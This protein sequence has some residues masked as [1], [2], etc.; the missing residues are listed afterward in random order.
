MIKVKLFF[1]T[2]KLLAYLI[3]F[4]GAAYSFYSKDPSVII[5][6]MSASAALVALKTYTTSKTDQA[7]INSPN[8]TNQTDSQIQ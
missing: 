8:E 1:T 7:K 5:T 4:V 2:S 6:A 3:F